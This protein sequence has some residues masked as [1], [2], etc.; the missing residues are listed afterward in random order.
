VN[1][2]ILL[3]DDELSIQFGYQKYLGKSGYEVKAVSTVADARMMLT[4]GRFDV[5]LL[6]LNLPD[7]NG[8]DL[9]AETRRH[10]PEIALVVITGAGDIPTAVKAMQLGADHYL[11]KPVDMTE[12]EVFL[13]KSFELKMLRKRSI[14]QSRLDKTD[15]LFFGTSSAMKRA[16]E[17]ATVAM[18]KDTA[19]LIC[20]ETGTGK[21]M[22]AKWIH[23]QSGRQQG[24]FVAVNCSSL[25]GDLLNSELFGHTKG[26]FTSALQDRA[27]LMEVADGGT[28]FLDEIGDMDLGVQAQFLKV[29]EDK[30]Y[31]RLGEDKVRY[32]DFRLICA[33][34]RDLLQ[35]T[36]NGRFRL[37]LYYR[38]NVYPIYLPALRER[39]DDLEGLVA[40][41]LSELG[42]R[43]PVAQEIMRLFMSYTWPGNI[44]ELRNVLE[45]ACLLAGE[46]PLSVEY[47]PGIG[48]TSAA[49]TS[50]ADLRSAEA[51]HIQAIVGQ[52]GGDTLKAAKAL[53]I[54]RATLYRKLPKKK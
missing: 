33:T 9:I 42:Y 38:I 16:V 46:Q 35:E 2:K 19:L 20:G 47:F 6:D 24:P 36:K 11:T 48:D 4:T 25:K 49:D 51:A 12:L 29:I 32:S 40:H 18:G 45:R 23:E 28:L 22:L 10:I 3:I 43:Q 30:Q 50:S 21:G 5:V 44:R 52:Y 13:R 39:L 14:V 7:G 26:A 53:G 17:F 15:R 1:P 27:G 34:H 37:D 8:I 41:L 54:S 31:R